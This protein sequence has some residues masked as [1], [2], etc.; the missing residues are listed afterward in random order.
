MTCEVSSAV[1][2][3]MASMGFVGVGAG[4]LCYAIIKRQLHKDGMMT[5]PS[6]S[7]SNPQQKDPL[8]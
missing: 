7:P 3:L 4:V 5:K 1:M 8:Q 2:F 6:P